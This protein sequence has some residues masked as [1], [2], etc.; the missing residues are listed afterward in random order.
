ML[1]ISL[2]QNKEHH[3][4][5]NFVGGGGASLAEQYFR[6]DV[7]QNS[8]HSGKIELLTNLLG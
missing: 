5:A 8:V 3:G 4:K 7:W 6:E 2:T 1:A